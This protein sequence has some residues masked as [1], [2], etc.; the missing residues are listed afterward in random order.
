MITINTKNVRKAVYLSLFHHEKTGTFLSEMLQRWKVEQDIPLR[1]VRLAQEMAYGTVRRRLSLDYLIQKVAGKKIKLKVKE[2]TLLRLAFYQHFFMDRIPAYAIVNE[3]VNLAKSHCHANFSALLN[4]LLRKLEGE[5]LLLPSADDCGDL[6]VRYSYPEFFVQELLNVYDIESV[7]AILE[8]G[9]T[10]PSTYAC[11]HPKDLALFSDLKYLQEAPVFIAQIDGDM[12]PKVVESEGSFIQNITPATLIADLEKNLQS[13]RTVLDICASPG[14]K[15][16]ALSRY[17]P[18]AEYT[19]NDVSHAKMQ[20]LEENFQRCGI[21]AK[22]S[23]SLG[24]EFVFT[25]HYD[26]IIL[27]VPC[28]NSGV[29]NKR[30]EARWRLD[31]EQLIALEEQQEKLLAHAIQG[32]NDKGQLWYMTCSILPQENELFIKKMCLKYRLECVGSSKII[33]PIKGECDGGF[34][35]SLIKK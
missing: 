5:E 12:V 10:V 20:R 14:G 32:L 15:T 21:Q 7:K 22:Y 16:M 8:A 18:D 33:L 3:M 4:A 34:A 6:S 35:C 28:S 26:L 11:I 29:L 25:E 24:E 1:D 13:P 2:R 19:V 31:K 9:N 27:D 30:P 23:V 17:F